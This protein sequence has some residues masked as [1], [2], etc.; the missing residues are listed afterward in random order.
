M[1][2]YKAQLSMLILG[3]KHS[4]SHLYSKILV[5]VYISSTYPYSIFIRTIVIET[6]YPYYS[7]SKMSQDTKI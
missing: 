7:D 5:T 6:T 3:Y 4:M 2:H 1:Y